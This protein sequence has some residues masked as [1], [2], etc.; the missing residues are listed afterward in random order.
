VRHGTIRSLVQVP[1]SGRLRLELGAATAWHI[2]VPKNALQFTLLPAAEDAYVQAGRARSRNFGAEPMLKVAGHASSADQRQAAYIRFQ[3]EAQAVAAA[4]RILLR[5]RVRATAANE[6]VPA[7]IYGLANAAWSASAITAERAPNLTLHGGTMRSI[8]DNRVSGHGD[9]AF[10]QGTLTATATPQDQFID[11]TDFLKSHP[12]APSF[13]ITQEVR[14]PGE[15][16]YR[17]S[18]EISGTGSGSASGPQ[19]IF[20]Y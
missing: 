15:L 17:G 6:V 20:L 3:P 8:A 2:T 19:L 5:L 18:I 9:S 14:Y 12:D 10:M 13:L 11:V 16:A 4:R 1:T 7:H